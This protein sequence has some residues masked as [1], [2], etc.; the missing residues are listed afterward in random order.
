M[1][2]LSKD[3]MNS[4]FG[5]MK[6]KEITFVIELKSYEWMLEEID[7]RAKKHWD[8]SDGSFVVKRETHETVDS[9]KLLNRF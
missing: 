8:L 4:S 2:R 6:I 5:Q 3:L 7:D 9:C 1:D